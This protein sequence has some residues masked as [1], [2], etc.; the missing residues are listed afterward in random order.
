[1][2]VGL[3]AV[4]LWPGM[5]RG[6]AAALG[7]HRNLRVDYLISYIFLS[8]AFS[9]IV[10]TRN[11]WSEN[12]NVSS[13][14]LE[15]FTDG[16]NLLGKVGCDIFFQDYNTRLSYRFPNNCSVLHNSCSMAKFSLKIS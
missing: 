2:T 16:T 12:H 10:D 14:N 4:G 9:L 5:N 15:I 1:M 13:E 7:K 3:N 8:K 11:Y 6:R